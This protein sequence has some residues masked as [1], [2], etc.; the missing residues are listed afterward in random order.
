M[1]ASRSL[2][3]VLLL[4][5]LLSITI[6]GRGQDR[7]VGEIVVNGNVSLNGQW[8]ISGSTV[9]NQQEIETREQSGA[10]VTLRDKGGVLT[11]DAVSRVRVARADNRIVVEVIRGSVALRPQQLAATVNTP[12]LRID[13]ERD[14]AYRVSTS[15]RGTAVQAGGK[16]AVVKDGLREVT[17]HAGETYASWEGQVGKKQEKK[18]HLGIIIPA[19]IAGPLAIGLAL[20]VSRGE[21]SPPVSPVLPKP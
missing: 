8:A 5:S 18:K 13:A 21:S 17:I 3:F 20:T 11:I 14:G 16:G 9:Y 12:T 6:R 4:S 15:E 2:A 7:A 10:I 1:R 19:L